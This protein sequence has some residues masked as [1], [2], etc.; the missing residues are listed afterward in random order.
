MLK[1]TRRRIRTSQRSASTSVVLYVYCNTSSTAGLAGA[2]FE[3]EF[4][5]WIRIVLQLFSTQARTNK[6]M[7]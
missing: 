7:L 6:A 3:F 5:R 1:I 4:D 2:R